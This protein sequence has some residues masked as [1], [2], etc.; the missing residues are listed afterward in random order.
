M[1]ETSSA[2]H[3]KCA[4]PEFRT[5]RQTWRVQW[6]K[7]TNQSIVSG[8]HFVRAVGTDGAVWFRISRNALRIAK[9]LHDGVFANGSELTAVT[10]VVRAMVRVFWLDGEMLTLNDLTSVVE[11]LRVV[12]E[13]PDHT[14]TSTLEDRE[15]ELGDFEATSKKHVPVLSISVYCDGSWNFPGTS[16][17]DAP[18]QPL[19]GEKVRGAISNVVGH[20]MNDSWSVAPSHG[21]LHVALPVLPVLFAIGALSSRQWRRETIVHVLLLAS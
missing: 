9:G 15:H 14:A 1:S 12:V 3:E 2:A 5:Q 7:R 16:S 18:R 21:K 17:L 6:R 10:V 8:C 11:E 4:A 20:R 19:S 13:R